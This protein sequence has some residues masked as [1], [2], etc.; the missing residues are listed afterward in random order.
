M[1][2]ITNLHK[3]LDRIH[4]SLLSKTVCVVGVS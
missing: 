3:T 4:P 2:L 1:S